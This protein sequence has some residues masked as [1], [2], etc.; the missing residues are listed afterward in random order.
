MK[1]S[2]IKC[3]TEV[4]IVTLKPCTVEKV[5]AVRANLKAEMAGVYFGGTPV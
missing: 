4:A 3:D 1:I 2:P 5:N